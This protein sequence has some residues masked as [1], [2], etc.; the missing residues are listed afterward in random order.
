MRQGLLGIPAKASEATVRSKGQVTLPKDG[1]QGNGGRQ[2]PEGPVMIVADTNV[3][4]RACLND[5]PA[6]AQKVRKVLADARL[7]CAN[8]VREVVTFDAHFGR[9]AK[10]RRL[11]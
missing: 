2:G 7:G 4:A 11:V 9:A 5:D 1:L 3:W 10:V 8:G 6:Q